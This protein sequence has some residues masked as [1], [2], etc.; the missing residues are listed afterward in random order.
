[1]W[2]VAGSCDWT[3]KGEWAEIFERAATA[4]DWLIAGKVN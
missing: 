3:V 4:C 1:M 2:D